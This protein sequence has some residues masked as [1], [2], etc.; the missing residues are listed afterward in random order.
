MVDC[1]LRLG[2][3]FL[4]VLFF[5]EPGLVGGGLLGFEHLLPVDLAHVDLSALV[6]FFLLRVILNRIFRYFS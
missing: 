6:S 4:F 1:R 2:S 3:C 5:V